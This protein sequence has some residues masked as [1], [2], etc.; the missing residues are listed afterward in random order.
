MNGVERINAMTRA[1]TFATTRPAARPRT[2][3]AL[4]GI[5]A[6][7]LSLAA[8]TAAVSAQQQTSEARIQD[9]IRLAAE[10]V[11]NGQ[12]GAPTPGQSVQTPSATGDSRPM[13]RLSLDEA[14]KLAL[15]RNLDIAVQ[16]LNPQINDIAIASLRAVY[17]PSLTSQ[18]GTQSTTN[19]STST[20]TGNLVGTGVDTAVTTYNG[21]VAQSLPWGG[22]SLSVQ[23][24]NIRQT[25]TGQTSLYNP[26]YSPLWSGQVTQPVLRGFKID[27]TRQQLQ[28]TKLTRDISDVQLR[29]SIINTLSNVRNAYWDYVYA[30]QSVE[31]AR[32]SLDLAGK[33][34]QDNQT[35]VQV[36]TMAPIDVVQAQSEAATRQQALVAA[37]SSRRTN[38]LALKRL[39][40]SGTEDPNWGAS[41]DPTDR[42]DFRPEPVD[43]EA[44]V[45]RAL[46]E[47]TDIAIVK[48]SMES[49]DVTLRYLRDQTLPQADLVGLYGVSGLGGTQFVTTGTGITRQV[50]GTIPGGYGD[51]LASLFRNSYPRWQV[52]MNF[53]YPLGLS[54][55][56]A[57]VARARVQL[58]QVAAQVKQVELQV[59]TDVTNAAINVQN[60]AEAV[61][62][63]Q[64]SR[65]LTQKKLEAEQSKFEVGMSTNYFVVQAQRDLADAQNSELR[66][67]LNYRKAIVELERNQQTTLQSANITLLN[68][69]GAAAGTT[70]AAAGGAA[71]GTTGGTT[72]T[73]R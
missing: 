5:F 20:I 41:L 40:V 70:A 68:G 33:L 52:S 21:G 60:S 9:L 49:N 50:T 64:A 28:V 12:L 31:V 38:E 51:A 6:A 35:R 63:A 73:G 7:T 22:S 46:S 62:A 23:L 14:V 34:V 48:K 36:G 57:A 15:D 56:E 44:A 55:Q 43:V 24:N 47:R 32:Q 59:A 16:R 19:P 25:T 65:E 29:A 67:V 42:P 3:R 58:S 13:V 53:S 71:G 4:T 30:V 66:A 1:M 8:A 11:A 39:I 61:Q 45:R 27:N 37:E 26:V 72:A 17:H 2:R 69:G 18:I 10:R 54:T